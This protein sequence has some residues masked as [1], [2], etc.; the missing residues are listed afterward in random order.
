[1]PVWNILNIFSSRIFSINSTPYQLL[2]WLMGTGWG[3]EDLLAK[4]IGNRRS[5]INEIYVMFVQKV[6]VLK[7]HRVILFI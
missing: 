1:M 4:I 6:V 2:S 3:R 5:T 7:G